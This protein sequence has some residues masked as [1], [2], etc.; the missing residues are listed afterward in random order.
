MT[1]LSG[2][3]GLRQDA[4]PLQGARLGLITCPTGLTRDLHSTVDVL[5]GLGNLVALFS[6]EHGLRG[7]R[8]AGDTVTTYTDSRTGLPVY[9]I[10]GGDHK[11]TKE[12]LAAID[13][14]VMDVQDVG[15]RYYTFPATMLKCMEACAEYGKGFCVLDRINPIGGDQVEGNILDMAFSSFVG[16]APMPIRHGLTMGELARF[17]NDEFRIGVSLTV[18]PVTGW[19]RDVLFPAT[20]LHW[21]NPSPNLPNMDGTLLYNGTC[22]IESTPLSEG[23]G[24]T[25]P[26]ELVG[27]PWLDADR[28]ADALNERQLPGV[29]FRPAYF[30]PSFSKHQ[31]VRCAGV[32]AHV[33]DPLAL[34]PVAMGLHLLEVIRAQ[35]VER[36]HWLPPYVESKH[37]KVDLLTGC[38]TLRCADWRADTLSAQWAREAEAFDQARKPYLLYA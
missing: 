20:G 35:S 18:V 14:L 17:F 2:I 26:F 5:Y 15:S 16:C 12:M 37:H 6:P 25:R 11:P 27:A 13:L 4:I 24:T 36:F 32:Q 38:D 21:I 29:F 34:R 9:S 22:L 28:L 3:D 7:E 8:E 31:G 19:S 30:T 1:V 23:R 33:T 10:Y